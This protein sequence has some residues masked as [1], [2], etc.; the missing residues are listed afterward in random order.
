MSSGGVRVGAGRKKGEPTEVIRVP[1]C[2]VAH[3]NELI[4][5]YKNDPYTYHA[6]RNFFSLRHQMLN[7]SGPLIRSKFTK[8]AAS[9]RKKGK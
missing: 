4:G 2:L 5:Y 3:F 6:Y 8:K 7:D 1:S 9:K